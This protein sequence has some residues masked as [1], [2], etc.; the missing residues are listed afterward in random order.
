LP[1]TCH[2]T[3][4][5]E[6]ADFQ[7]Q[8]IDLFTPRS[9][10]SYPSLIVLLDGTPPWTNQTLTHLSHPSRIIVHHAASPIHYHLGTGGSNLFLWSFRECPKDELKIE[11]FTAQESVLEL[12]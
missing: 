8:D 9:S 6:A 7:I 5:L 1:P 10:E 11:L 4:E 12:L 2:A 3:F